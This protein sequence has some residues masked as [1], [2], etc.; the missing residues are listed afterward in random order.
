MVWRGRWR[1]VGRGFPVPVRARGC[2]GRVGVPLGGEGADGGQLRGRSAPEAAVAS[3]SRPHTHMYYT[4]ML[5]PV[6]AAV[7]LV[8]IYVGG[9]AR[10]IQLE[11][12]IFACS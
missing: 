12:V 6:P 7:A 4:R 11:C 10:G 2:G 8:V 3:R 5:Q 9:F 1:P